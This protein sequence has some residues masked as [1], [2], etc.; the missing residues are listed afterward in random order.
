MT[1]IIL[2]K[3][4]VGSHLGFHR[5]LTNTINNAVKHG[6]YSVQFFMGNPKSVKRARILDSDIIEANAILDRYP[7]NVFSHFPYVSNLAG[8]VKSL[9]WQNDSF[10]N[11]KT[12][13]LLKE[14]EY[15][16]SI[17]AKIGKGVVI[18]PGSYP[19]RKKGLETIAKSIN[20]INF[21]KGSKLILENSAGAGTSLATTFEEMKTI[22]DLVED[23]KHIGFCVDTAHIYGYGLYDLKLVREVDRMFED[24][25]RLL[26]IKNFS[27]LHLN[28]SLV[29]F[30]SKKDRHALLGTGHIW[31]ECFVSL[32]HLLNKCKKYNIPIILET[33]PDDIEILSQ[34]FPE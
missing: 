34:L 9:A 27:L 29:K 19:D 2:I 13:F 14:I 3:P 6:V 10:Q 18:H 8:S 31:S 4:G 11:Q 1:S 33:T 21:S 20:K 16:L 24:F 22:Y 17:L 25:D 12:L 7:M 26:G 5:T 30:R 28:D 23:K 32:L 15:E